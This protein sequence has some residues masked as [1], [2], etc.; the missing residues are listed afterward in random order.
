MVIFSKGFTKCAFYNDDGE[1]RFLDGL[2]SVTGP[3]KDAD[4]LRFLA[5]VMG[6]R[7]F[8]YIAF[9]SGS[10]LGVGRDQMHVYESLALPFPLPNHELAPRNAEGIVREAAGILKE[11][12]KN[13]SLARREG[14]SERG[15]EKLERL[16][17]AYFSVT[18]TERMLIEDT[19]TIYQ[20]S[21]HSS[22]LDAI[23]RLL[24]SLRR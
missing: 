9:H 12:E 24:H 15:I 21:I 8:K 2:R 16:V 17:E 18:D 1:V 5:A 11:L 4:L 6:S 20:P 7:L 23:S 3:K 22:N 10:N 19:L 14:T 13:K